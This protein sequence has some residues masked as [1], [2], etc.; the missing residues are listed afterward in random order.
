MRS[1]GSSSPR[2]WRAAEKGE[3]PHEWRAPPRGRLV[4]VVPDVPVPAVGGR[5]LG[6][7]CKPLA[8]VVVVV[9]AAIASA[10]ARERE[11]MV[12]DPEAAED[13]VVM[14]VPP[15][16]ERAAD[17]V[18]MPVEARVRRDRQ[19]LRRPWCW[20]RKA[21][22]SPSVPDRGASPSS[23]RRSPSSRASRRSQ[24]SRPVRASR[25]LSMVPSQK[26]PCSCIAQPM[27]A[28]GA[29]RVASSQ[30]G[31][32][33]VCGAFSAWK[34]VLRRASIRAPTAGIAAQAIAASSRGRNDSSRSQR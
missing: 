33:E 18:P 13:V 16:E 9:V 15:Q 10:L 31:H 25:S 19:R 5:V 21:S 4:V 29:H 30:H 8:V 24:S 26:P 11:L 22:S 23:W 34:N 32:P 12:P 3:S 6:R 2:S 20:K 1:A 7:D 27:R 14:M 28:I 17:E